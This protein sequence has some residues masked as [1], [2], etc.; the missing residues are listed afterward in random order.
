[1][2]KSRILRNYRNLAPSKFYVFNQKVSTAL[3]GN[4]NIPESTWGSNPGL[5]P[6]YLATSEKHGQVYHEANYGSTLV[7]AERATLQAQL[8]CKLDEIAS[9]LEAEAVRNPAI[10]LSCGFDL[11]KECRSH[12]RSMAPAAEEQGAE[13]EGSNP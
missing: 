4:H 11:A 13:H 6:S 5:L 2:T 9:D 3:A 8:V 7:I 10:L 12:R 1:M